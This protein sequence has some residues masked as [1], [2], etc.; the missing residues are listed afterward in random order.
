MASSSPACN[1]LLSFQIHL[2]WQDSCLWWVCFDHFWNTF[3]STRTRTE[4]VESNHH[5][6]LS[7]WTVCCWM[8]PDEN[9]WW[10]ESVWGHHLRLD[11]QETAVQIKWEPLSKR[12]A[13]FGSAD[14]LWR[15]NGFLTWINVI[16][17]LRTGFA[18]WS[19]NR[20]L[21]L[22]GNILWDW[23]QKP[24]LWEKDAAMHHPSSTNSWWRQV[25]GY[26]KQRE[27]IHW[28]RGN[29]GQHVGGINARHEGWDR[30]CQIMWLFLWHSVKCVSFIV[31]SI[32]LFFR[33]LLHVCNHGMFACVCLNVLRWDII[34]VQVG[35][36]FCFFKWQSTLQACLGY[37]LISTGC[38]SYNASDLHVMFISLSRSLLDV[39]NEIKDPDVLLVP[40]FCQGLPL[41]ETPEGTVNSFLNEFM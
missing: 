18:P 10:N 19:L 31:V 25:S 38:R 13:E 29:K 3:Y 27:S 12:H 15:G 32:F 30:C 17:H 40:S 26:D 1:Q 8:T 21:R 28:R 7:E 24:D 14:V 23:Q 6:F 4:N 41:E 2:T 39:E 20:C 22:A 37:F 34:H 16:T 33:L 5:S 11:G 35:F 36:F 9:E